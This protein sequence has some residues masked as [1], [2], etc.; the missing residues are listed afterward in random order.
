[1]VQTTARETRLTS[2]NLALAYT[3]E[4]ELRG[5]FFDRQKLARLL[6]R[7]C[8][9][10]GKTACTQS[11]FVYL[12][13]HRDTKVGARCASLHRTHGKR[14]ILGVAEKRPATAVLPF[15]TRISLISVL[16]LCRIFRRKNNLLFNSSTLYHSSS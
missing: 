3:A 2:V 11:A 15:S 4:E 5:P 14:S 13:A 8:T 9:Q 10:A 16:P 6:Q 1:V 7:I 12:T